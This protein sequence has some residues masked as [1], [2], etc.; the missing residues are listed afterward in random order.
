MKKGWEIKK[1]GEVCKFIRGPFGGSLKKSIFKETG[2][3]VYEQ[4]HAIYDR[5]DNVRYF[6]DKDK[7]NEMKRFELNSG[8]LI[9]SCSGTIG[10]IA[11]VPENIEKGIINQALLIISPTKRLSNIFLKLW[12]QSENFQESLNKY[13][14]GAAIKNIASV[15]VLKNIDIPIPSL[16]EQKRIVSIL[17]KTFAVIERSR[18]NAEQNL[19][20][21]KELFESYLQVVFENKGDGWK[22]MTI[23]D[24]CINIFAGGDKPKNNFSKERNEKYKVPIF[25]NAVKKRGLYG[26]TD[27]ARVTE[28]CIT[29]SARGSGTGHTELRTEPFFP[30]VRLIV[31]IPNNELINYEFLKHIVDNLDITRSGSAIPQLTVPMMK[32]YEISLPSIE[33]Q[34][35]IV[36]KLDK[37][38]EETKKLESI[39][40]QKILN[41][42]DLKKSVLQKA[43]NGEL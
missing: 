1:F 8:D 26:Y 27:I 31:L 21:A 20:N 5:F 4:K 12:M 43:F 36:Q 17:D 18:N 16:P 14:K 13:S 25:A 35:Q 2:Y 38:S 9:M 6:V 34:Q 11:I 10:K 7:F 28:P 37:L 15:K 3:A 30:I 29:I 40:Q 41:L 22:E 42:E 24:V 23:Q 39:Y 33:Q 19:K 32:Q